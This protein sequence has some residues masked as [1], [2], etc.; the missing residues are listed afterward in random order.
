M[1]N[2]NNT[3][4]KCPTLWQ[5]KDLMVQNRSRCEEH[6]YTPRPDNEQ[7]RNEDEVKK[8]DNEYED[9]FFIVFKKW[10]SIAISVAMSYLFLSG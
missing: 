5:G 9:N 10:L 2:F 7:S 6:V 8:K 4:T 1:E 3:G